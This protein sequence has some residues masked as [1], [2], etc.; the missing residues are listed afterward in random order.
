LPS[1]ISKKKKK[2]KQQQ[3]MAMARRR[4]RRRNYLALDQLKRKKGFMEFTW[5]LHLVLVG[6]IIV[7]TL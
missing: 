4:R 1:V 5:H 6:M 2:K 7:S 3:R